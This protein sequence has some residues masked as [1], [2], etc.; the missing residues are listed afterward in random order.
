V[1]ILPPQAEPIAGHKHVFGLDWGRS[2]DFTAI[3]VMDTTTGREVQLDRFTDIGY[4]VQRDRIKVLAEKWEPSV[5][6]A[7]TNSIGGPN[8]EALQSDG[9]PVQ[10]FDT[11]NASKEQIINALALAMER[12]SQGLANGVLLQDDANG[13]AELQGYE[14]DRLPSGKWRFAARGNGHDDTVIARG[15]AWD[16]AQRNG[17]SI[18]FAEN[19]PNKAPRTVIDGVEIEIET[20]PELYDLKISG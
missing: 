1:C 12:T 15:L 3:S 5:I 4:A 19:A 18:F 10:G 7:E 13:I 11:T 2:N 17:P 6:L 8:I 9:L 14:A 20:E 16:A